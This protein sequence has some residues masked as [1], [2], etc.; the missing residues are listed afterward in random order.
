V[1]AG[2]SVEYP[3][4]DTFWGD[5]YA[6]VRD[7]YGHQWGIATHKED[8]PPEEMARRAEAF[9]ASMAGGEGREGA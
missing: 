2:C 4:E 7:P 9:F 5:R 6:K 3:L 8:V 1:E